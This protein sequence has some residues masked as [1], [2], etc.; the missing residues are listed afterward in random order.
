MNERSIF[1]QALEINSAADR[2]EFLNQACADDPSLRSR[3]D[4]LLQSYSEAGSFLKIPALEQSG[5]P[6]ST[7]L[8]PTET[9]AAQDTPGDRS[10]SLNFL[11]PTERSDSLGRLGHYEVLEVVG[12]GGM[13]LVMRAFDEKLHRIV[14]IK[15]MAGEIAASGSGRK[16]F[17][18]EAKAVAAVVH[19]HIVPI[20]AIEESGSSPYLVMQFIE[21]KS[22]QQKID[23]EGSLELKE[24]L[25]IGRQIALGLAAAHKQGLVHRDIKPSNILLENGVQRVKITDFGLARAMDDASI[26]HSGVIAG[27]PQFMSPEQADGKPVDPRSDL[28]SLGSVMYAMCTGRP[29]FRADSTVATLKR[30]CE[31]TPRPIREINPDMREWLCEIIEKL[32]AKKPEERFQSAKD[33]AEVLEQ[34]LAQVQQG[35]ATSEAMRA[36]RAPSLPSPSPRVGAGGWLGIAIVLL[37]FLLAAASTVVIWPGHLDFTWGLLYLIAIYAVLWLL[38]KARIYRPR[39]SLRHAEFCAAA[40]G[41]LVILEIAIYREI[42]P[43]VQLRNAMRAKIS[44]SPLDSEFEAYVIH[45]PGVPDADIVDGSG[46][47]AGAASVGTGVPLREYSTEPFVKAWGQSAVTLP[48]GEYRVQAVGKHGEIVKRWRVVRSAWFTQQEIERDGEAC[49][50]EIKRGEQFRLSVMTW[51]PMQRPPAGVPLESLSDRDRIQGSWAVVSV[52]RTGP[53]VPAGALTDQKLTITGKTFQFGDADVG[54]IVLDPNTSPKQI[55]L[56]RDQGRIAADSLFGRIGPIGIY[57]FDGDQLVLCVGEEKDRPR[58]FAPNSAFPSRMVI[59]LKRIANTS[60]KETKL[61]GIDGRWVAVSAEHQGKKIPP[62]KAKDTFPSEMVINGTQYG[63]TWGR[64]QHQGQLKIDATRNPAEIDFSGSVFAD[65]KPSQMI[66]KLEGDRLTLC[67]PF[68]GPNANPPR[69]TDFKTGPTSENVVLVYQREK[70]TDRNQPAQPKLLKRIDPAKEKAIPPRGDPKNVSVEN[71]A[72]R[73]VND[74][75]T[76]NFNVLLATVREGIPEDGVIICRAKVKVTAKDPRAWGSLELGIASPSYY[77]YDW[78]SSSSYF[79]GKVSDWTTKEVRYPAN[80]F[81]REG[82]PTIPISVGLHANGTLWVKDLELLHLPTA[83]PEPPFRRPGE[84]V[85]K[86]FTF[87]D[88]PIDRDLLF[89]SADAWRYYAGETTNIRIFELSEPKVENCRLILRAR[90]KTKGASGVHLRMIAKFRGV[91]GVDDT[92]DT[93][94]K[95][96]AVAKGD[97]DWANYEVIMDLKDGQRPERIDLCLTMIGRDREKTLQSNYV[98][99]KDVELLKAP[100]P[101]APD[102]K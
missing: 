34:H 38:V 40:L 77:E 67:L 52:D 63:L 47:K 12:R 80:L 24:I 84:T 45:G 28:F 92:M 68:A 91:V 22:L 50:L 97:N 14:A 79:D 81:I 32:H 65:L 72:W 61:P 90:M 85:V 60:S 93:E 19:D 64:K 96:V 100:L 73:I 23:D 54:T 20:Y 11:Q 4:Q 53:A 101:K 94:G 87:R 102:D 88:R 9:Q 42:R 49:I 89:D 75:N 66:Y 29:P 25:R 82:P 70:A 58:A 62:E 31:D 51:S 6:H 76:G 56:L 7:P 10:D 5:A 95:P 43:T 86:S 39:E 98:W 35:V 1:L 48:P 16:R 69:P 18:R 83:P 21:G 3:V 13:G 8:D 59:R 74:T 55:D 57:R 41:I 71:G 46:A 26:S 2:T 30:V 33:V 15:V 27:T 44:F 36:P 78:P 17:L 99:I 37:A